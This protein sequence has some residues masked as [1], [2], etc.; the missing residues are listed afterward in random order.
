MMHSLCFET[1][2]VGSFP[3]VPDMWVL[4]RDQVILRN[5]LAVPMLTPVVGPT[6][7]WFLLN[8]CVIILDLGF[9]ASQT[10]P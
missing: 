7:A 2:L 5:L 1:F 6:L 8:V 10:L 9:Q 4:F 3:K